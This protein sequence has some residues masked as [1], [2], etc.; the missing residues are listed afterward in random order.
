MRKK[1]AYIAFIALLIITLLMQGMVLFGKFSF[2]LYDGEKAVINNDYK[3]KFSTKLTVSIKYRGDYFKFY[4]NIEDKDVALYYLNDDLAKDVEKAVKRLE[5]KAVSAE[6]TWD[7]KEFTYT[8]GTPGIK[9]DRRALYSNIFAGFNKSLSIKIRKEPVPPSP[10][11]EDLLNITKKLSSYTTYFGNS[12]SA[13]KHN[14]ALAASLLNGTIVPPKGV[15]S[16]NATVGPRKLERGFLNAHIISDGRF[17]EGVGGGVCQVSTTLYNA[18]L[19]AGAEIEEARRHSLPIGY[20]PLS[21]DAMVS[22]QSDL[23]FLNPTNHNFYLKADATGDKI[24]FTIY[25]FPVYQGLCPVLRS[26]IIKYI[27]PDGYEILEDNSQLAAGETEKIIKTPKSGYI[28]EGYLDLYK[29]NS[30]VKSIKLR[31]DYY[32]PQKGVKIV[33]KCIIDPPDEKSN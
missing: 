11:K 10:N 12:S 18:A 28:S 31:R 21:F 3:I 9:I 22:S 19:L 4:Q 8:D 30:L 15:F 20:V 23:K 1:K 33:R 5:K 13:R 24:T 25:G 16:F 2:T 14:I 32:S 26:E 6:V 27:P 29:G 17:I 7:G